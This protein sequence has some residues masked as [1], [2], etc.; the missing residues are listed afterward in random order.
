MLE[1]R[2]PG[3]IPSNPPVA[4]NVLIFNPLVSKVYLDPLVSNVYRAMSESSEGGG[5]LSP[6]IPAS[7]MSPLDRYPWLV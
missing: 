7:I 3:S 1:P 5:V 6:N 4:G 2:V